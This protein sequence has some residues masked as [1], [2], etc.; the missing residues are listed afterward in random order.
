LDLLGQPCNFRAQERVAVE[1]EREHKA[2][3]A[4]VL[5]ARNLPASQGMAPELAHPA[6][7]REPR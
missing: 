6:H 7:D 2:A 4:A 1:R 5:D 3:V